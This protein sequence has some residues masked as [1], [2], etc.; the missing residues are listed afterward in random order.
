M[1][2]RKIA[3]TVTF[4]F[5]AESP[6]E[7][8]SIIGGIKGVLETT[9]A[10]ANLQRRSRSSSKG[11]S[12]STRDKK[13]SE[14]RNSQQASSARR[15]DYFDFEI[16]PDDPDVAIEAEVRQDSNERSSDED[17]EQSSSSDWEGDR[18]GSSREL[19]ITV[20][21]KSSHS[22]GRA[23]EVAGSTWTFDDLLCGI[24]TGG[25]S[26]SRGRVTT[27]RKP[28]TTPTEKALQE[29]K[30]EYQIDEGIG[31]DSLPGCNNTGALA[32]V[33]DVEME[34]AAMANDVSAT[35]FCTDDV[36]TASLK[37]FTDTMKGI[38][39]MKQNSRENKPTDEKGRAMAED[40]IS[41][42]LGAPTAVANLLSVKDMWPSAQKPDIIKKRVL[43]NRSRSVGAQAAHFNQLRKRMTFVV[44]DTVEKMP[45]VQLVSSYDDVERSGRF[46][47]KLLAKDIRKPPRND[48]TQ[49]LTNVVQDLEQKSL[50]ASNPEEELVFYDS[51][52]E[53]LRESA[54]KRGPRRAVAVRK[55][56]T[57]RSTPRRE[58]LADVPPSKIS[59]SRRLRRGGDDDYVAGII[60]TIK[61]EKMTLLWH[62]AQTKEQP[63]RVPFC[64][65]VWIESGIYLIDG[66]FLLPKLTWVPI[67][68]DTI[69][70]KVLNITLSN[71]GTIDLLDVCR[72]RECTKVDRSVH[73]YANMDHSFIVQTQKEIQLFE[74]QSKQERTRIVNGLRLL[75]ARLASLLM[76]RDVRAVDEFFGGNSVPGEA[77]TWAQGVNDRPVDAKPVL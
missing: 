28:P 14:R 40:Y 75:I 53:D 74:A 48:S 47:K 18:S 62:P 65:K 10:S 68:E 15:P 33:D 49:F 23:V 5:E 58:A 57:P 50:P 77:P 24:A 30:D 19:A 32:T 17:R 69:E 4:N 45:L 67:S 6:T 31:W 76:L 3:D 39:E 20:V 27:P 63:N 61:N 12:R 44:S 21:E 56:K 55:N 25:Q 37:D 35:P 22:E 36:C 7:R 73:P 43:Q 2:R 46:L 26:T 52:P 9:K 72:V 1:M 42:V 38:F 8:D 60:E 16:S 41:G 71:P 51:D 34:L 59:L 64:S 70:S 13:N 54:L 29:M 11:R 66:T